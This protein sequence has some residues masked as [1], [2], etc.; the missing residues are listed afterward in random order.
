MLNF[1]ELLTDITRPGIRLMLAITLS[2]IQTTKRNKGT[3]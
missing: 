3:I 1:L 2:L